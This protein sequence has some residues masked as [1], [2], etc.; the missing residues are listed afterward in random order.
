M[1]YRIVP[2][3]REDVRRAAA[4]VSRPADDA[5]VETL[6][7]QWTWRLFDNPVVTESERGHL[8]VDGTGTVSG[9][10]LA[11]PQRFRSPGRIFTAVCSSAYYVDAA[12][13]LQGFLL[14]RRFRAQPVDFWF[15]T[16]SNATSGENWRR[17]GGAP[18]WTAAAEV[19]M[20]LQPARVAAAY[21]PAH[22]AKWLLTAGALGTAPVLTALRRAYASGIALSGGDIGGADWQALAAQAL[23]HA[24]SK[25]T[26][27]RDVPYL[28]WRYGGPDSTKR[29]IWRAR[30]GHGREGWIAAATFGRQFA[31]HL[32]SWMVLDYA[33]PIDQDPTPLLVATAR[34]L[35]DEADL[36]AVRGR[37]RS[38]VRPGAFVGLRRSFADPPAWVKAPFAAADLDLAAAD[39]D[40]AP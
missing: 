16:T 39:G 5:A 30:D 22:P 32:R 10:Q 35:A 38:G 34:Q 2:I 8:V 25:V 33:W 12:A 40:T 20:P 13:R 6:T 17:N 14:Y 29:R 31:P 11:I 37:A 28:A 7:A 1:A 26:A 27:V 4:F 15:S 19:V 23:A 24:G 3:K 21:F 18:V 9:V 36:L